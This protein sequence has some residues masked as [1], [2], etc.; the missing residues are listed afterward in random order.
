MIVPPEH[1][2]RLPEA[3]HDGTEP[4]H[5]GWHIEQAPFAIGASASIG[6]AAD[7]NDGSVKQLHELPAAV[8][9]C[10]LLPSQL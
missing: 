4:F 3:P 5:L 6:C 10:V 2:Q 8:S 9:V 1:V 7:A